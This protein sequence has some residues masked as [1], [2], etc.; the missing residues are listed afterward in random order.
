MREY[1]ND[2]CEKKEDVP[3]PIAF[4]WK[5]GQF[6]NFLWHWHGLIYGHGGDTVP[7]QEGYIMNEA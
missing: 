7:I 3:H 1:A 5:G 4:F 2:T 6:L